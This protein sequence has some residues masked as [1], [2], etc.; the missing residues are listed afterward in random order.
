MEKIRLG[1]TGAEVSA[2]CFGTM[3]FGNGAD[4]AGSAALYSACRDAGINFFDCADVYSGGESERILGGLIKGHRDEVF[5][6]SKCGMGS[7]KGG[8]RRGIRLS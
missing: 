6:T 5:I 8:T 1:R 4:D 7:I 2:L 3:T